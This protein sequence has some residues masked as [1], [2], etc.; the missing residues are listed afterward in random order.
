ML[1]VLLYQLGLRIYTL[2][3]SWYVLI[4]CSNVSHVVLYEVL[5]YVKSLMDLVD[6]DSYFTPYALSVFEEVNVLLLYV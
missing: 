2:Y 5:L 4:E 1:V 6:R 3:K